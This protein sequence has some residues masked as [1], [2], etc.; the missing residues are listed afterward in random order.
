MMTKIIERNSTIPC[1]KSQVFST[2]SDNQPGCTIKVFEGERVMTKDNH[3]LGEFNLSNIPPMPRGVP[4]IEITYDID[5]NGI[6]NVSAVEK[7]SG[8]SKSISIQND[9]GRLSKDEIDRMVAEAEEFK[10]TDELVKKRIESKNKLEGYAF[11]LKQSLD[12][13]KD[14]LSEDD[15]TAISEKCTEMIAWLDDNQDETEECYN[16]KYKELEEF[17]QPIMMKAY[18]AEQQTPDAAS[19]M[20]NPD[21]MP[22]EPTEIP[23][24]PVID[25]V[26]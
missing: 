20:P 16:A 5:A 22:A 11:Q 6:L 7:S 19:G 1:K 4:Q 21:E 17:A 25:E 24:V 12:S 15:S 2:F 10:E 18:A 26:D 14:K 9:R 23:E 8:T 13:L 3:Q